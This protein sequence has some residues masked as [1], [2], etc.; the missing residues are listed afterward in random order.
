[1]IKCVKVTIDCLY[2]RTL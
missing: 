1:M 2:T